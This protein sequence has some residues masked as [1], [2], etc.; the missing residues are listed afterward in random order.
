MPRCR[1]SRAI[2]QLGLGGRHALVP[3]ALRQLLRDAVG[4]VVRQATG[5]DREQ[6]ALGDARRRLAQLHRDTRSAED[7]D[8]GANARRAGEPSIERQQRDLE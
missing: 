7:F 5:D 3:G 6:H 1:L 8:L 4:G 2:V